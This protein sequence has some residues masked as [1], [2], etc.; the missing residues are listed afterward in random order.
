MRPPTDA[1]PM[2]EAARPAAPAAD[3]RRAALWMLGALVSFSMVAI[4]GR[5][6]MRSIGALE[7]LCWRAAIGLAVLLALWV[8]LRA[9]GATVRSG[10]PLLTGG[11]ALV[12]FGAQY[13]WMAAVALIP[14]VEVFALEFTAPLWVAVL[15]P[16]LLGERLTRRRA[17]AAALGF[18]GALIVVWPPGAGPSPRAFVEHLSLGPG[19]LL[20]LGAAVGFALN[21][22]AVRRLTRTDSPFTMLLWMHVLQ[23]PLAAALVAAGPGVALVDARTFFWA[24]VCGLAGLAAHYSLN[25]ASKLADA[26]V[27]APMDFLRVPLIA[28]V[29]AMVYAEPLRLPVLIGAAVILAANALNLVAQRG[30]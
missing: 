15:A 1:T 23:L 13:A 12:H 17:L 16:L 2:T 24:A 30:R 28:V 9:R 29:G 11:R 26:I 18:V 21:V 7:L 10:Q 27:V 8:P 14:L 22:M 3:P 5:E 20:A 4:S 6:A 25:R 19:S